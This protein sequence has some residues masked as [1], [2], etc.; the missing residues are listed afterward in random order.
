MRI[1]T[2]S[3]G[4]DGPVYIEAVETNE[5]LEKIG[6]TLRGAPLATSTSRA[7]AEPPGRT[8]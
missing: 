7:V 2:S 4:A 3:P 5:Q 8:P 1:C 6:A